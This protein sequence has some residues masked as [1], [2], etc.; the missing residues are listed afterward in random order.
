MSASAEFWAF[1]WEVDATLPTFGSFQLVNGVD[2]AGQQVVVLTDSQ[3]SN[4]FDKII[5]FDPINDDVIRI[6]VFNAQSYGGPNVQVLGPNDLSGTPSINFDT[7]ILILD[8]GSG[9]PLSE[10]ANV[11]SVFADN[12]WTSRRGKT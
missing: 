5:G 3:G 2:G 6:N 8:L 1:G 12:G 7:G 10:D 9:T 11:Q 4:G